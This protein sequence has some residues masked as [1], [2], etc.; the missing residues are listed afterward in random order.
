M[1]RETQRSGTG[2][3]ETSGSNTKIKY[4]S[5]DWT[6]GN[7]HS[8]ENSKQKTNTQMRMYS[9]SKVVTVSRYSAVKISSY[10][11]WDNRY[12]SSV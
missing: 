7:E 2:A 6:K 12:N 9:I 8:T 10:A 1:N 11:N 3:Y 5:E 4:L